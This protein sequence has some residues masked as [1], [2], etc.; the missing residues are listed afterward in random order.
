MRKKVNPTVKT[1]YGWSLVIPVLLLVSAVQAQEAK[2]MYRV[3]I[4]HPAS[5]VA[6]MREGGKVITHAFISG[7]FRR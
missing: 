4:V 7:D 5:P 2:R 3:A 6:D 1:W